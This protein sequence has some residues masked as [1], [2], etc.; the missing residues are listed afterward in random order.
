[1]IDWAKIP[2]EHRALLRRV[3]MPDYAEW[4]R[5]IRATG[6]CAN[7]IRIRGWTMKT[8]AA[9]GELLDSYDTDGSLLGY[10][11]IPCGN[12]RAAVCPSCS[13]V[14]RYDARQLVRAGL[15]GGKGVPATV[16]L[17]PLLFVTLT[18]PSFG[19]VH[20]RHK[21]TGQD[22]LPKRC[23]MR[24][25]AEVCPHGVALSCAE[26][27]DADDPMVGQALCLDCYDYP[28]AVLFNANAGELWRRLG[29]YLHREL[30]KAVGV[31][32]AT[33]GRVA[34]VSY[35]KVAEYQARGVVH[36]HAVFR[37]DGPDGP[38]S[39]PPDWA[40]VVLL[41]TCLRRSLAA[42]RVEVPD[43]ANPKERTRVLRFGGQVDTQAI[44]PEAVCHSDALTFGAV[45][46]YIA[47]Y[48]TKAAESAGSTPRPIHRLSDVD[49]LGLLPHTERMV[50]TCFALAE[51]P[52]FKDMGL[53][54]TQHMLGFRGH[55]ATKSRLYSTTF[56]ALRADRKAHRD[57]ERRDRQGLPSLDGRQIVV[58]SKWTYV[59][60]G[61]SY[62]ERLLVDAIRRQQAVANGI[63]DRRDRDGTSQVA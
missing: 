48:A 42:V 20:A 26:R 37:I 43:S 41:D 31:S 61:L 4:D 9:T 56:G 24:S 36:F 59:R 51:M 8:D 40:T 16:A 50:R 39:P 22:G 33:L 32:R 46:G 58:D 52:A 14:Y 45:A 63:H 11:L 23:H 25:N 7:P 34:R 2:E 29:I 15:A 19:P 3:Q 17:H 10:L 5:Q 60:S 44:Y 55:C 30:A 53:Y 38:T 35:I 1:V 28:G 47:K 49:N 18:A 54:R 57:A 62:G 6:A 21:Q 12:R 13:Q 27:H